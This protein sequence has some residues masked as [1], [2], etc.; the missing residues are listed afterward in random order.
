MRNISETEE[1]VIQK[2][3]ILDKALLI[4]SEEE[5]THASLL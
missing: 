3:Y 4:L 5:K 2:E 1:E